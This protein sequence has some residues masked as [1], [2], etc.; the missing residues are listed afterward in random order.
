MIRLK[1]E[2]R[3]NLRTSHNRVYLA[4]VLCTPLKFLA[5]IGTSDT[6]KTIFKKTESLATPKIATIRPTISHISYISHSFA[7]CQTLTK[8]QPKNT[9]NQH[10]V[11]H[12]STSTEICRH[13]CPYIKYRQL[14]SK[15]SKISPLTPSQV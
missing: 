6:P 1:E 4:T 2:F 14:S 10:R 13:D 11:G 8:F 9:Q 7:Y 5:S 12:N 3:Y 15:F